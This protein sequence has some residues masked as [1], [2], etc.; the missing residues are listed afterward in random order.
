MEGIPNRIPI[1]RIIIALAIMGVL[2][3]AS[4]ALFDNYGS[5]STPCCPIFADYPNYPYPIDPYYQFPVYCACPFLNASLARF[6]NYPPAYWEY[7]IA[8]QNSS[9]TTCSGS[10]STGST[11][12]YSNMPL[13]IPEKDTV[14]TGYDK[15][16]IS[17]KIISKDQA[18]AKYL[19]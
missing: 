2:I 6:A 11:F 12:S 5:S 14:M 1:S 16:S 4:S 18:L 17:T 15:I 7:V 10:Y 13:I 9:C 8:D 19:G 3:P